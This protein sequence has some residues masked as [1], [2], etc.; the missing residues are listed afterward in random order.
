MACRDKIKEK[1]EVIPSFFLIRKQCEKF[2]VI[3][4]ADG[5]VLQEPD[6]D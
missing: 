2:P 5:L 1:M 6:P 3:Y 4:P